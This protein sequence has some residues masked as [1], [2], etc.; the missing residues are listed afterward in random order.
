MHLALTLLSPLFLPQVGHAVF[1]SHLTPDLEALMR[2]M[3]LAS[4]LQPDGS[5]VPATRCAAAL[6]EMQVGA[7]VNSLQG[8]LDVHM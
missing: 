3:R 6:Q 2:W 4:S 1:P 5:K 7:T 8:W